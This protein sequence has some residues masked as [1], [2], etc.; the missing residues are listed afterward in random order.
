MAQSYTP[1][2]NI[3]TITKYIR[4]FN[5]TTITLNS[6]EV[7]QEDNVEQ[8]AG[9]RTP[10]WLVVAS[11]SQGSE[12]GGPNG[13]L[14]KMT[15]VLEIDTQHAN[16]NQGSVYKIEVDY[17]ADS[18]NKVATFYYANGDI[19]LSTLAN[20]IGHWTAEGIAGANESQP[21]AITD[22]FGGTNLTS[23][24]SGERPRLI[25]YGVEGG[26]DAMDFIDHSWTTDKYFQI[27]NPLEGADGNAPMSLFVMFRIA[28][29]VTQ[30]FMQNSTSSSRFYLGRSAVDSGKVI[31]SRNNL[32]LGDNTF[33]SGTGTFPNDGSWLLVEVHKDASNN[34]ELV[35]NGVQENTWTDNQHFG[36]G[37]TLN[38]GN[39]AISNE[40]QWTRMII[41]GSALTA[42]NKSMIR[43]F[44]LRKYPTALAGVTI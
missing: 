2:S 36:G 21:A 14:N 32:G 37:G 7:D 3:V 12:A 24:T 43:R 38:I 4:N 9:D 26:P 42:G 28:T 6:V 39:N 13:T 44:F 16:I 40:F 25:K 35:V 1:V 22:L 11:S 34:A 19:D 20:Q 30:N 10:A 8:T 29:N 33:E 17:T 31:I 15:L 41:V 23:P 5:N 27:T 18:I